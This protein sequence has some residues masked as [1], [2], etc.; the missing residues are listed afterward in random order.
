MKKLITFKDID[1]ARKILGLGD[2][3]SI[4]DIKDNHRKFILEY[5]PD[6]HRNSSLP[7]FAFLMTFPKHSKKL[8]EY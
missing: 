3:A 7:Q 5:H 4:E 6:R 8:I 1:N 2:I